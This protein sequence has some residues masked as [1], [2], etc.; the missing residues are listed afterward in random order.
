MAY[1]RALQPAEL[2]SQA[3]L[4]AAMAGIGMGFAIAAPA[5]EPNI[6]DTLLRASVEAMEH[7]DLRVLAILVGWFGI[8]SPFVNADRLTKIVAAQSSDRVRALWSAL[9]RSQATDRRFARLARIYDGRRVDAL[10][11]GTDF[12]VKRRGEDERFAGSSLRVPSNLLR[13]RKGDVLAPPDLA[14]RHRAYRWR[15]TIGP[16][17]RAD[18]WAALDEEPTLSAAALARRTYG[19]FATAWHTRRDHLLVV[20]AVGQDR[21]RG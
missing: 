12:Q 13:D 15:I 16:S 1:R 10:P 11:S 5:R 6:E 8:H 19:S 4:T 9:A 17:Y 3:E 14:R 7:H 2:P 18:M 21:H 20:A